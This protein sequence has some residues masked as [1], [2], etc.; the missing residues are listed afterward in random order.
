M[1]DAELPLLEDERGATLIEY[2]LVV[3]LIALGSIVAMTS[4]KSSIGTLMSAVG[5]QIMSST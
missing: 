3:G 1:Q 4:L 5:S 2:G